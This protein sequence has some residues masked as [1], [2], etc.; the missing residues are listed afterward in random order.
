[1]TETTATPADVARLVAVKRSYEIRREA[2]TQARLTLSTPD[3]T[4]AD[5]VAAAEKYTAFL[6]GETSPEPPASAVGVTPDGLPIMH[7]FTPAGM[8]ADLVA[9]MAA[10]HVGEQRRAGAHGV[11]L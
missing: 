1:M 11:D 5:V 4:P 3:S 7:V 6:T 9:S 2:L 10:A 8:T